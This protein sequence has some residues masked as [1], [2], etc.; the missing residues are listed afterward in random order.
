M[1]SV[2]ADLRSTNGFVA[3]LRSTKFYSASRRSAT[4][5]SCVNRST[6]DSAAAAWC[7]PD[8]YNLRIEAVRTVAEIDHLSREIGVHRDLII[9]RYARITGNYTR[10]SSHKMRLQWVQ[11]R[12]GAAK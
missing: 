5:I 7:I 1:W 11:P 10:F 12:D 6:A 4:C 2:K 3:I 8:T 9:G